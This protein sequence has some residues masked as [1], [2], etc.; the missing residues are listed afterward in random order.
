MKFNDADVVMLKDLDWLC[1][2]C[3]PELKKLFVKHKS[4]EE[5]VTSSEGPMAKFLHCFECAEDYGGITSFWHVAFMRKEKNTQSYLTTLEKIKNFPVDP[6]CET[7]LYVK[8]MAK[9]VI[10]YLGKEGD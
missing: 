1:T 10:Y 9:R 2:R 3:H 6:N 7:C 8:D 4:F 5:A